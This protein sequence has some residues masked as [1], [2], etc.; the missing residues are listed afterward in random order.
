MLVD[1]GRLAYGQKV[2]EIWPEYGQCGK[3]ETTIAEV[4]RHEA[5]L[6]RFSTSIAARDLY[7]DAIKNGSISNLIEKEAPLFE[8][9]PSPQR[10]TAQHTAGFHILQIQ[11]QPTQP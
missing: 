5:G 3:A 10:C 11:G 7:T 9:N 8:K 1:R 6:P 4:M 2:V